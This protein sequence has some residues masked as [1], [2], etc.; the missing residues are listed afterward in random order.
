VKVYP[1]GSVT[2]SFAVCSKFIVAVPPFQP[3]FAC[4]R[5]SA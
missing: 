1:S 2:A 3:S 4:T 5:S